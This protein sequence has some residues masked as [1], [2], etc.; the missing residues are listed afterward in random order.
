MPKEGPKTLG[1]EISEYLNI[2]GI[3]ELG[4]PSLRW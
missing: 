3:R 4:T 2:L 1:A